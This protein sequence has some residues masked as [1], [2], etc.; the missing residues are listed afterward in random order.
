MPNILL[1]ILGILVI[2]A[3]A[4]L[5]IQILKWVFAAFFFL[6][7]VIASIALFIILVGGAFLILKRIF[8]G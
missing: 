8:K 7:G 3:I 2:G 6:V 4:W 1:I 5:V